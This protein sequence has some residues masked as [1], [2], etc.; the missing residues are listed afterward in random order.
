MTSASTTEQ[1]PPALVH[2]VDDDASVRAAVED[3]LAS[4]AMSRPPTFSNG[5]G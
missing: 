4:V 5:P 3:L 1:S 2:L